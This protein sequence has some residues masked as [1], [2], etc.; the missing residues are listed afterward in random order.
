MHTEV[1]DFVGYLLHSATVTHQ[2]H[3]A[4]DS[5]AKHKALQK[6]YEG[7]TVLADDLAEAYMGRH[8]E[9][10]TEFNA[11]FINATDPIKYLSGVLSFV[12]DARKHL[13]QDSELQNI[14]DEIVSLIDSTLYKLRF[15]K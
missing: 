6:Y 11:G 9:R 13:P 15:L 3:W 7:V 5:Y 10:L 1:A 14:V 4:T 2:M 8:N 12:D